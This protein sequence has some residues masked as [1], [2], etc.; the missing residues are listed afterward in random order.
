MIWYC[1]H[2]RPMTAYSICATECRAHSRHANFS[3]SQLT[4]H[5]VCWGETP[6]RCQSYYILLLGAMLLYKWICVIHQHLAQWHQ[7]TVFD[8]MIATLAYIALAFQMFYCYYYWVDCEVCGT[9]TSRNH[10]KWYIF[11][12]LSVC[13]RICTFLCAKKPTKNTS[14]LIVVGLRT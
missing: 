1:I 10:N 2:V 6:M 12:T 7:R 14:W 13:H 3:V 9:T 5:S 11:M 8:S 4:L